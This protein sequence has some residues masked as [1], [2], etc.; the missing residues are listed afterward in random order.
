MTAVAV[1]IAVLVAVWLFS[2]PAD[3]VEDSL[4]SANAEV[5][6]SPATTA[7]L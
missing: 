2:P 6:I 1:V 3:R 5:S 7:V 4:L